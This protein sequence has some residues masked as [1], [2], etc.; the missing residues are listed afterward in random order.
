MNRCVFFTRKSVIARGFLLEVNTSLAIATSVWRAAR[1]LRDPPPG[2]PLRISRDFLGSGKIS[3][4]QCNLKRFFV[5][6]PLLWSSLLSCAARHCYLARRCQA[7]MAAQRPKHW[8]VA[9]NVSALLTYLNL[10]I[11]ARQFQTAPPQKQ[12]FTKSIFGGEQEKAHKTF[13]HKYLSGRPRSPV[14]PV[15]YPDRK[16]YVPWVPRIAHKTLTPGLP[17]GRP[18]TGQKD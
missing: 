3:L 1:L 8:W 17:V 5:R 4:P 12:K 9:P 10:V 15:G 7:R 14:L 16:I 11:I 2:T 13:A 6:N 18:L